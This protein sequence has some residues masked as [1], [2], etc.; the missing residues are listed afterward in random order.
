MNLN[1][2]TTLTPL[3]RRST[4]L[5]LVLA[6]VLLGSTLSACGSDP[7]DTTCGEYLD[8]S[9]GEK[10]DFLKDAADNDDE[11]DDEAK[12]QI[13]EAND[14]QLDQFATIFDTACEG[15]DEDTKLKDLE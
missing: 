3:R 14:E 9:A 12:K 2:T 5:G 4:S 10:R 6:A 11:L 15:E 7:G 1:D 8:Y 13:E